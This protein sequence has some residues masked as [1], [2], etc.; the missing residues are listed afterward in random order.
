[1]IIKGERERE[2][3]REIIMKGERERKRVNNEERGKG[4][5]ET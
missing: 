5:G 3:E 1:M 4:R 2:F